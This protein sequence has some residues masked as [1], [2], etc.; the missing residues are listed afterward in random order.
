MKKW[1][2]GKILQ[3]IALLIGAIGGTAYGLETAGVIDLQPK[4]EQVA[5]PE[6]EPLAAVPGTPV[7]YNVS[8]QVVWK[9][10]ATATPNTDYQTVTHSIS[11]T[12]IPTLVSAFN[13][14]KSL[15]ALGRIKA[16]ADGFL[17]MYA[18]SADVVSRTGIPLAEDEKKPD[19]GVT[20]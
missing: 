10:T 8:V 1:N 9:Y 13:E 18:Y 4:T 17:P 12:K 2:W 14:V 11:M 20:K 19:S 6:A 5:T 15:F 16:P 7:K 3:A